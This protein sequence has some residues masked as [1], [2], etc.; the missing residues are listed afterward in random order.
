VANE[1]N[2]TFAGDTAQLERAFDRVGTAARSMEGDVNA[3]GE[4]FDRAAEASDN[5]DTKAMGF[6]DTLTG[7]QDGFAGLK[8]AS[9]GDIGFE[10]LLLL[11]FGVGDLASGFTNFLIPSLKSAVTWLKATKAAALAQAAVSGV[12]SAATKVW[13]GVQAVFNAI[14]A[15]NPIVLVIIAIVALIAIIIIA[16]KN[17]ETFRRIVHAAFNGVKVAAQA[18]WTGIKTYFTFV[19]NMWKTVIGWAGTLVGKIRSGFN[20]LVS[21]AKLVGSAITAP[22]RAA[23]S[24]IRSLWNSTLGGKGFS[25]PGWVPGIGGNE[26]RIPKFHTGGV[27]PGAAGSE[28]LAIL[29]AGERVIPAGGGGSMAV[30]VYAAGGGTAVGRKMS[31]VMLELLR[32]GELGMRVTQSGRVVGA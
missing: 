27:V 30:E 28:M 5:V 6:R 25:I 22:F 8:Q 17:S 29:Q 7:L 13:A 10:S 31:E 9:S 18:L 15:M 32:S 11:G 14:M 4:S 26:F 2:L 16:Y 23:F 24:A 1:V 20:T 12:V 21:A 3:A 19:I